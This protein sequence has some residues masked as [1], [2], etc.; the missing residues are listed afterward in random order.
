MKTKS[1]EQLRS[2]SQAVIDR[3]E[4]KMTD[5]KDA[6][7][8]REVKA[9]LTA[10][11]GAKRTD[12]LMSKISGYMPNEEDGCTNTSYGIEFVDPEERDKVDRKPG[13]A[14]KSAFYV[15]PEEGEGEC[16][17]D[18]VTV[19]D[20]GHVVFCQKTY[21]YNSYTLCVGI[22]N[23]QARGRLNSLIGSV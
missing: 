20:G 16:N 3:L 7:K 13:Y 2:E 9:I 11:Y 14:D 23:V 17:S 22:A 4:Q 15:V 21:H 8:R 5:E 19:P 18:S 12:E 6:A 1:K 10:Q